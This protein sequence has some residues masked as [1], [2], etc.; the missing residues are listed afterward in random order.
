LVDVKKGGMDCSSLM[1]FPNDGTVLEYHN[2]L[3][4]LNSQNSFENTDVDVLNQNHQDFE[5]FDY[6]LSGKNHQDFLVSSSL[7]S[8]NGDGSA[9][10]NLTFYVNDF[11]LFVLLGFCFC[12]SVFW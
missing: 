5:I 4:Q 8:I 11:V 7:D 10:F 6:E 3:K 2:Y 1:P 9:H 12:F